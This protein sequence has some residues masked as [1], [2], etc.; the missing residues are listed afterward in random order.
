MRTGERL[1]PAGLR[2]ISHWNL[3]DELKGSYGDP[4]RGSSG[5]G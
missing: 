5:S 3:R 4:T 2:L 1:F